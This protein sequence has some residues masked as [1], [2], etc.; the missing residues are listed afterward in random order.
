MDREFV[1]SLIRLFQKN[2]LADFEQL[3]ARRCRRGCRRRHAPAHCLKGSAGYVAA[4][5]VREL[6]ARL[7]S[8]G[9]A[10]N[11]GGAEPCLDELRTELKRCTDQ[12]P[13]VSP[14]EDHPLASAGVA[15]S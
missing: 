7:E 6:A 2:A 10:G 15:A 5:R 14:G 11:L 13:N 3:A 8:M 1:A 9:R 4:S 12:A